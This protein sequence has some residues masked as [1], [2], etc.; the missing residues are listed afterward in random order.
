ME[1][2][3]NHRYYVGSTDDVERRLTEHNS[4]FVISTKSSRPWALKKFI[5]CGSLPESR[6]SEYKLKNYKSRI[7]LEKV[8]ESGILPWK[9]NKLD[10][11][12]GPLA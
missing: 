12:G 8:I 2:E 7:I 10:N 1:S 5:K 3:V 11:S 9:Y 6:K 4:G